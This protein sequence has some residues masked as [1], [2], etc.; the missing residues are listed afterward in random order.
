MATQFQKVAKTQDISPGSVISVQV[1]G[2]GVAICN[3]DGS[4][5]AIADIC[6][7]DGGS[8]DQGELEDDTIECPRHGAMFNVRTG[9]V[10]EGPAVNPVAAYQVQVQGDDILVAM[11]S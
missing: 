1:N 9:A 4:F 3:V 11:D 5:F 7:H 8:L 10:V 2:K 6:T